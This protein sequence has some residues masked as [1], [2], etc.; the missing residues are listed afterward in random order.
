MPSPKIE[1]PPRS[2]LLTG[3]TVVDPATGV[4]GRQDVLVRDGHIAAVEREIDAP[5][6]QVVD[7]AGL[8]I[9]PGLIDIHV[10][11]RE[12]GLEGKETIATGAAAALRGGFTTI[13]CKANTG[14][15]IDNEA[16]VEYIISEARRVGLVNVLPIAAVTKELAGGNIAPL[17]ELRAAG[18]VALSDDGHPIEQPG[19]LLNSLRYARDLGLLVISHAEDERLSAGGVISAGAYAVTTGLPTIL[20]EAEEVGTERDL[21]IAARAGIPLHVDHVSTARSVELIRHAKAR[22][23]DISGEAAPHHFCLDQSMLAVDFNARIKMNPPIRSAEDRRAVI[24]GLIDGT[25]EIIASDH[26]PHTV[27]EKD[28]SFTEAPFGIVGLETM[29]GLTLTHLV[30]PGHLTFYQ[31]IEKLST[32]PAKR[33]GLTGRGTLAPGAIADITI[34]D[35]EVNWTVKPEEF[36]SKGRNTPFTGWELTGQAVGVVIGGKLYQH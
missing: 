14:Q 36:A 8:H 16:A 19:L 23:F 25:L 28:R 34:I 7:C 11:L 5:D 18:A 22:G 27:A 20:K 12:P 10:H 4:N 33:L 32:N 30:E 2:L 15:F 21:L 17:R 6:A 35:R 9:V 29:L 3:G 26:A 31:A 1:S 13:V 24:E